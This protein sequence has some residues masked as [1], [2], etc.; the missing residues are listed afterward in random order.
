M[1]GGGK[2]G[3][4]SPPAGRRRCRRSPAARRASRRHHAERVRRR[5]HVGQHCARHVEQ[6][7]QLV[8]PVAWRDVE[9]QRARRIRDVG[10]VRAVAGE[11]PRRARCPPCRRRARRARRGRARRG[12][13]SSSH[14]IL[15][16][17]KYGSITNP[18]RSRTRLSAPIS[19][20]SAHC[21]A[22]R[23]SCQTMALWIG[24]PVCRSQMMVVSRW[25]VMPM[26][27]TSF[28]ATS[29]LRSTSRAVSRCVS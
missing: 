9:Q 27:I 20:S 17:L 29:A 22:V 25:L 24:S 26:P 8:V 15:V 6:L 11:V 7:Q 16:P 18:V 12:T 10:D 5:M 1:P 21:A 28:S 13:L 2:P 3:R 19:F 4:T 14:A 23:R